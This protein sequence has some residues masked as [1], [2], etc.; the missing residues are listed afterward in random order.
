MATTINLPNRPSVTIQDVFDRNQYNLRDAAKKSAEWLA[1]EAKLLGQQGYTSRRMLNGVHGDYAQYPEIGK[2][3]MFMYDA[4]HKA[5]LPYWDK[6]PLVFPFR[7]LDDGFIGVNL[8]YLPYPARIAMLDKL[9][10]IRLKSTSRHH[11][12]QLSW[13]LIQ[14]VV[15]Y[16]PLAG[17]VHRYLFNHLRSGLRVIDSGDW[18]TASLLPIQQFVGASMTH[19][20]KENKR[21][22]GF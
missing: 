14:G 9:V 7:Q 6:F 16:R 3:Y 19:V 18:A 21:K 5:T 17:C 11:K 22:H 10:G 15:S 8:H 20:H 4:K 2:M 1:K 13:D 12:I